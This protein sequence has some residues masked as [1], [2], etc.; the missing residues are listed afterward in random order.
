[1]EKSGL[2]RSLEMAAREYPYPLAAADL[3]PNIVPA[4]E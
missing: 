1:M 2:I 4:L 3:P